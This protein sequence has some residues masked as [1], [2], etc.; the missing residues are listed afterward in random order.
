MFW[1]QALLWRG[2]ASEAVSTLFESWLWQIGP[3]RLDWLYSAWKSLATEEV[4]EESIRLAAYQLGTLT[5]SQRDHS[6]WQILILG[7]S[8]NK[9]P[10]DSLTRK[11]PVTLPSDEEREIYFI[12][13]MYQGKA[14]CAW[15]MACQ[16]LPTRVWEL[17][18]CYVATL[19]ADDSRATYRVCLEALQEYEQLLGYH[20][21][22]YDIAVRCT[23]VL[24][25]CLSATQRDE[26]VRPMA[27]TLDARVARQLTEWESVC[28][29][30]DA[31]V[32]S[33]P[34]SS[35]Y[36]TTWRGTSK[37]SQHNRIQLHQVERHLV[38]CPFWDEAIADY[39][40]VTNGVIQWN[41][42]DAME[43]YYERYFP[44][45]IPDEWTR[46]EKQKSH[47]EGVL[48]PD[49]VVTLSKYASRFLCAP[50]RF[51]WGCLGLIQ[52]YL[53][54][55]EANECHPCSVIRPYLTQSYDI[56]LDKNWI[57]LVHKMKQV[58]R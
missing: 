2:R 24:M 55:C 39:G 52:T 4:T 34:T 49:E 23:A 16:L 6:V 56:T 43:T 33:L 17:L 10:P 57:T 46:D 21:A 53:R 45:D 40:M 44:D 14:R 1:C 20:S 26:S 5:S 11:T 22:E 3:F 25:C 7:A 13:A 28:G 29:R 36:G 12:R 38:G 27:S 51:T 30:R 18:T 42:D 32:Y 48:G 9:S 35:L 31:R 47:G 8:T 15:W 54:T 19:V 50:S 37:W 58:M 41:S